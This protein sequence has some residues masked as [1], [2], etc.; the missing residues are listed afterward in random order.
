[1]TWRWGW[2]FR[3]L[4]LPYLIPVEDGAREAAPAP[5]WPPGWLATL[6]PRDFLASIRLAAQARTVYGNTMTLP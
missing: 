6:P 4:S 3:P 5:A 2:L 1:M